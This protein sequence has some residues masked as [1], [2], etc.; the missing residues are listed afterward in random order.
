MLLLHLLAPALTVLHPSSPSSAQQASKRV[1]AIGDVHGDLEA[2]LGVLRVAGLIDDQRQWAGGDATLVQ[3]G[4]VLDRGDSEAEC[5][6]LLSQLTAEA[7]TQGGCVVRLIGNHELMNVMGRAYPFIHARGRTSFGPD[8]VAAWAQGGP[9]ATEL[10]GCFVVA[11]IGD[12]AFVHAALPANATREGCE[13]INAET[14]RWLLDPQATM[15]E[16]MLGGEGSPVWDRSL[17]GSVPSAESCAALCASLERLGVSRVVV[18]HT[19]QTEIN[20]ACE[21]AVW[22][23]DTGMSR[24]VMDGECQAI[25]ITQEGVRVLRG[26]GGAMAVPS[27]APVSECDEFACD[28]IRYFL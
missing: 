19:P 12:S 15:P 16:W 17:S 4:D 25:E 14:R 10:A 21:G 11:L 7:P 13:A 6:S 22:R 9:L 5:W 23:C 28:D 18:G 3:L 20:C 24:W 27:T 26:D 8:R 1:V 2:M